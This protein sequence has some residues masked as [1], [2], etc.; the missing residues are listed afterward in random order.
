MIIFGIA[1]YKRRYYYKPK[2]TIKA[3][4]L[5]IKHNKVTNCEMKVNGANLTNEKIH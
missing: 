1:L 4:P 2:T 5:T 3:T